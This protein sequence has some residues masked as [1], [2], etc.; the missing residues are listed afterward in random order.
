MLQKCVAADPH[1]G[2]VWPTI[3]KDP[4]NIGKDL[5]AILELASQAVEEGTSGAAAAP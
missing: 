3:A 2:Q 1:H 4:A 5:V